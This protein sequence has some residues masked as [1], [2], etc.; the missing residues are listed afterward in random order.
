MSLTIS[1]ARIV[2]ESRSPLLVSRDS[3]P[4][5]PLGEV[6]EIINGFAFKSK[7]FVPDGGKP[8]IRIRDIFNDR[9]A[10]S[11]ADNYADRYLVQ[12]DELLVGMDGDFNC[13]RWRGPEALLNQ[14]VCKIT[15]DPT[16]LDL[17]F[18]AYVLPGYLQAIH[19]LTSSTTVTHL[20]SRDVAQIPIPVPPLGEQQMLARLFDLAATKQQS[21]S[22]HLQTVRR[23]I[24]RFRQAV[25]FAACSGRL[26][27]DWRQGHPDLAPQVLATNRKREIETLVE[28][29]DA[30]AWTRL[31]EIADLKGGI[32]KGA[33][34]KTDQRVREVPYLRVA[35][36]QRGWL[37]LSEIKTIAVPEKKIADLRL[38]PGDVLFNE[39]GDRDKLGRGW[40]WEGQIEEC[41]HQNHV[42]RARLHNLD[43]QPRFYS[44]FGNTIGAAYFIDRGKQTV[45]LASLNMSTLKALP[46][47]VPSPEEQAEIVRRVDH[48]LTL[49]DRLRGR[50]EAT[51]RGVDRSLQ[52]ILAKAFRGE[53][54][55][56][57]SQAPASSRE[58]ESEETGVWASSRQ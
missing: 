28:T 58:F 57:D 15:P 10:V 5:Q 53:L 40:I 33:K 44:W 2:E 17:D 32:Q 55:P 46:V 52:A 35:N 56:N 19:D 43:M 49:A 12:P 39:G 20:S 27:E 13:A 30:W 1:P 14:R 3:W 31:A 11:Y 18:L 24:E 37:D 51:A 25:L 6:A 41:V 23:V 50:I 22:A 42:F 48:L 16:R 9:T 26:T 34:L 38:E 7:Q 29:P 45:N 8:L 54:D 4:R 36:V 21:S 47:P